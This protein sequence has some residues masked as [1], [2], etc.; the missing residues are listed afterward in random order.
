MKKLKKFETFINESLY[1]IGQR[2]KYKN[3]GNGYYEIVEVKPTGYTIRGAWTG[4]EKQVYQD[5][6]EKDLE[7]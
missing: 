7:F 3:H 2:V 5:V 4:G 1:S 6:Q